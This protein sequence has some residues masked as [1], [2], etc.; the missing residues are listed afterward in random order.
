MFFAN[1][2][3][4]LGEL[5]TREQVHAKFGSPIARG[6]EN[7]EAFEE[8]RTRRKLRDPT[9]SYGPIGMA[10][11]LPAI[12]VLVIAESIAFPLTIT[13]M[14][15]A[16]VAGQRLRFKYTEGVVT[17]V[18]VDG[19]PFYICGRPRMWYHP[20]Q[21][22]E[23]PFPMAFTWDES[24]RPEDVNRPGPFIQPSYLTERQIVPRVKID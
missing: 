4:D 20:A 18:Y 13:Q 17:G 1:I 9:Y 5:E 22:P 3:T 7:G 11:I 12:P 15:I 8:F 19:S 21:L 24:N 16:A 6:E 10:G 2:G 14:G 23:A